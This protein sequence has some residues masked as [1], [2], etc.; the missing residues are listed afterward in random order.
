MKVAFEKSAVARMQVLQLSLH[1]KIRGGAQN[2]E[3][4]NVEQPGFWNFKI[5]NI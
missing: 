4:S 2:M 3:W 5:T 1:N